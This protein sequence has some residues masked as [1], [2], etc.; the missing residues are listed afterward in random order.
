M[1]TR[2]LDNKKNKMTARQQDNKTKIPIDRK[3]RQKDKNI[4]IQ[5]DSQTTRQQDNKTTSMTRQ[6]K[7]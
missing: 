4:K 7:M 2:Q 6:L 3:T 1:T 5:N